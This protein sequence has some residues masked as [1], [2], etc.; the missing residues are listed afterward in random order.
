MSCA[1]IVRDLIPYP[2]HFSREPQGLRLT[3]FENSCTIRGMLL[4]VISKESKG[5]KL[6]TP[7]ILCPLIPKDVS[8]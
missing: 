8:L 6:G 1:E 5:S 3:R 2:L 4:I 7:S